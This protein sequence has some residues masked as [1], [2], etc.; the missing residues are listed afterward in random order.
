MVFEPQLS[1][2]NLIKGKCQTNPNERTFYRVTFKN[3]KVTKGKQKLGAV[4][5][6]SMV[7]NHDD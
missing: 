2:L 6:L 5:D 7:K 3:D 4:P 1:N